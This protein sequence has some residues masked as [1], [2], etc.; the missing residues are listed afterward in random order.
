MLELTWPWFLLILPLPFVM[1]WLPK[2]KPKGGAIWW[3]NTQEMAQNQQQSPSSYL[4]LHFLL[5]LL[6]WLLLVSAF[7]RP[8]WFGEPTQ[9]T[10]SGRDLLIALDLSGSMQ[11]KDMTL[12]NESS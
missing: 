11:T 7:S 10:P 2:A 4:S 3:P 5:L 8:I 12:N 6:S 9:V 1:H